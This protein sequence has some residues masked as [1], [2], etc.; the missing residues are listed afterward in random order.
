MLLIL[1]LTLIYSAL[2]LSSFYTLDKLPQGCQN[3]AVT[4][5]D[6][7]L[8]PKLQEV[9]TK[10]DLPCNSHETFLVT[11][12]LEDSELS[13]PEHLKAVI[14]VLNQDGRISENTA[15]NFAKL[16]KTFGK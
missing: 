1:Y 15:K 4:L 11:R 2:G 12:I 7:S 3:L 16:V 10:I 13:N 8:N 5:I 6:E 14:V 9:F